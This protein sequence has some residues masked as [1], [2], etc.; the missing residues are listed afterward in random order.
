MPAPVA[1]P[2]SETRYLDAGRQQDAYM[3]EV[4]TEAVKG[5]LVGAAAFVPANWALKRRFPYYR[6][7]PLQGKAFLGLLFVVPCGTVFAEK[8]G[9]HFIARNQW[10]GAGKDELDKEARL[11]EQRWQ[12][13]S[14][15]DKLKDWAARHQ[16]SI[17]GGSW[18]ASMAL[19]FG[20]VARD[21]YQTFPQKI[22]QA[23]M[24]A[25]GLTVAVLVASAVAAGVNAKGEKP[26]KPVDHS[27]QDMLDM[28][29]SLTK[30]ERI[31]LHA[32]RKAGEKMQKEEQK[33]EH[34]HASSASSDKAHAV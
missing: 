26:K 30:A 16:Y 11:A 25:Q 32:A 34:E 7:L 2:E 20:I 8:A 12:G 28:N 4:V 6:N 31:Q 3:K 15:T 14:T 27:W 5:A 9:E 10:Q 22:V 24:W 21:R 17:I 29:G 19:A 18:V 23:R 1:N 33:E 13:L